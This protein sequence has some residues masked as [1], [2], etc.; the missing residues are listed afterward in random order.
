M[1]QYWTNFFKNSN[2][3]EASTSDIFLAK[4]PLRMDAA[5]INASI[6]QAVQNEI[7]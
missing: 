1:N 2:N 3:S 7:R 5:L 6:R 4:Y